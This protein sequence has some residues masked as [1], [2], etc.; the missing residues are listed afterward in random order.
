MVTLRSGV[1]SSADD[2]LEMSV[3]RGVGRVC[4]MCM[5]LSRFVASCEGAWCIEGGGEWVIGLG[6]GFSYPVVRRVSVSGL[7]WCGW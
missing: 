4:K 1:V 5:C 3:I 6:M 2:V 7:R